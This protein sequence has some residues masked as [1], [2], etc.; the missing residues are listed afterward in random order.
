[1]P[2]PYAGHSDESFTVM[3]IRFT[4]SDYHISD[5]FNNT[6][7]HGGPINKDLFVRICYDPRDHV[8]LRL[9]IRGFTGPLQ[10]YS[11]SD[12][13]PLGRTDSVQDNIRLPEIENDWFGNIFILLYVLDLAAIVILF[14][15]YLRTF[16]VLRTVNLTGCTAP[17]IGD[18]KR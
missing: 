15:P 2:M 12:F 7:S 13:P 1:I 9:L 14:R 5:G 8:I 17:P 11:K 10:D 16:F 4:Y 18:R 6:S 3:G